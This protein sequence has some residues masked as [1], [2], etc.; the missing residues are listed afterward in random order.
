M[1][2]SPVLYCAARYSDDDNCCRQ[3]SKH[4]V[5]SVSRISSWQQCACVCA[6]TDE[7][8][9]VCERARESA[10]VLNRKP[11][12]VNDVYWSRGQSQ[13]RF[14]PL[15]GR[16]YKVPCH[17]RFR[18]WMYLCCRVMS[19]SAL[20]YSSMSTY[21]GYAKFES[22]CDKTCN[23]RNGYFCH[24]NILV[25]NRPSHGKCFSKKEKSID[26]ME[27]RTRKNIFY[28]ECDL[29]IRSIPFCPT[30]EEYERKQKTSSQEK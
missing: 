21:Y 10:H 4:V 9:Y 6:S 7:C 30:N 23:C 29:V 15:T 8:V 19:S 17:E 12:T 5:V 16:S 27:A 13:Q 2:T 22:L 20:S 1:C 14:R 11:N 3:S 28:S 25:E 18:N 24:R 26:R